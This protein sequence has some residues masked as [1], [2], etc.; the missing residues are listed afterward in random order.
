MKAKKTDWRSVE[1]IVDTCRPVSK[2][3][4][5]DYIRV[6]ILAVYT[7]C[8]ILLM[9]RGFDD[10]GIEDGHLN[11][12]LRG[13]RMEGTVSESFDLREVDRARAF[14]VASSVSRERLIC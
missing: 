11:L 2:R 4:S 3:G 13:G 6:C 14:E 5:L 1:S 7:G 10:V 12:L 9:R 8:L